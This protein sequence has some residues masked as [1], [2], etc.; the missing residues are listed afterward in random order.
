[1]GLRP[2][3][4]WLW[5]WLWLCV[6][7]CLCL[8]C[9]VHVSVCVCP[10]QPSV[11][12]GINPIPV[13]ENLD[14]T[15][16]PLFYTLPMYDIN[17]QPDTFAVANSDVTNATGFPS[18]ALWSN[19]ELRVVG[20]L[21]YLAGKVTFWIDVVATNNGVPPLSTYFRINITLLGP[22]PAVL[23]CACDVCL[24]RV[25]VTCACVCVACD[26]CARSGV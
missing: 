13:V 16:S 24:C 12:V 8:W 17:G 15:R 22:W 4:L 14:Y 25:F 11:Y 9:G 2:I 1:M 18:I 23:V 3:W 19:G 26:L 20:L 5:L 21:N 10:T 6:R 7:V